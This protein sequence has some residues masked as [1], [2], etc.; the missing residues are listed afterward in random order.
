MAS[1]QE[2]A[3]YVDAE[4]LRIVGELLNNLKQASYTHLHITPGRRVLDV[5]CGPG[6]DTLPL[7]KL[8]SAAGAGGEVV[9]VDH[10][11]EM[12]AEAERRAQSAGVSAW[13]HHKVANAAAIPFASDYFDAC[14]SERLFQHLPDRKAVLAEMV[15]VTKPGGW[16]VVADTDWGS[17]SIDSQNVD[18]QSL[19][20]TYI[21]IERRF[22]R[23]FIE[24]THHHGYSGRELFGLF[25]AQELLNV[26]ARPFPVAVTSYNLLDQI[27]T[28]ETA[29]TKAVNAGVITPEE[30]QRWR[31]SLQEADAA[32]RF[33][34]HFCLVLTVGRKA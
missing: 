32:G 6:T 9:G 29:E 20:G 34:S 22:M 4:Y 18:S 19:D 2:S 28:L 21:D 1:L 11:E 10:D 16:V 14:R 24:A 25:K 33:Y 12:I 30:R 7:A 23:Y 31:A 27:M 26:S 3:G 5:G 17:C 13:T 8:V 15:R